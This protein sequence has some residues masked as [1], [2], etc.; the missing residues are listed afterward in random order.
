MVG[1]FALRR[2][3]GGEPLLNLREAAHNPQE[4]FRTAFKKSAVANSLR[5]FIHGHWILGPPL[6]REFRLPGSHF[7]FASASF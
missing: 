6:L 5:G 2:D 7:S 1:R 4:Y 3:P